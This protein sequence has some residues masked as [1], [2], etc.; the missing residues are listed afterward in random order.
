VSVVESVCRRKAH[1]LEQLRSFEELREWRRQVI[2]R[3]ENDSRFAALVSHFQFDHAS[4]LVLDLGDEEARSEA[5]RVLEDQARRFGDS[6]DPEVQFAVEYGRVLFEALRAAS[7]RMYLSGSPCP[8]DGTYALSGYLDGLER[9][10]LP[11]GVSRVRLRRG[12]VLPLIG[13][14]R[15]RG[16]WRRIAEP[17]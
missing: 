2:A 3:R 10:P 1:I 12:D 17:D 11:D 13:P 4:T 8:E 5:I 14:E 9:R 6:T 16:W 7:V 15:L